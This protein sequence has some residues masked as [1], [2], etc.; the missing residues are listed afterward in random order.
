MIKEWTR[1]SFTVSTDKKRLDIELIHAYLEQSYWADGREQA[2]VK[3]SIEKSVCFGVYK[4]PALIGFARV[5]TDF[6]TMAYL[7]DVFII[8]QFR[9]VGLGKFLMYC[10]MRYPEFEDIKR[11][12]LLTQDAHGLYLQFGFQPIEEPERF[13]EI[14]R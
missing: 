7:A 13:M 11:W 5:V 12:L 3:K 2:V 6:S 10:I 14:K 4:G 9:G 1:D 8:E